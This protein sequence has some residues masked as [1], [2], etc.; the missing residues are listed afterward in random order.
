MEDRT[1]PMDHAPADRSP[2]QDVNSPTYSLEV[3]SY[4][5]LFTISFITLVWSVVRIAFQMDSPGPPLALA[6]VWIPFFAL[7]IGKARN[8]LTSEPSAP[9]RPVAYGKAE[10]PFQFGLSDLL[11]AVFVVAM[12]MGIISMMRETDYRDESF[13]DLWNFLAGCVLTIAAALLISSWRTHSKPGFT[14]GIPI[15]LGTLAHLLVGFPADDYVLLAWSLL[16]MILGAYRATHPCSDE[17]QK[18]PS[19]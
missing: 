3:D 4:F 9:S 2:S 17:T 18:A 8:P 1:E 11:C 12:L 14:V 15:F 5:L 6:A 16:G 19:A 7:T 13:I 10:P